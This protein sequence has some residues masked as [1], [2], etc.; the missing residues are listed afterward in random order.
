MFGTQGVCTDKE[1]LEIS[2]NLECPICLENKR[3]ISQP[4]CNHKICI[5]CFRQCYYGDDNDEYEPEAPLY[6]R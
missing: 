6:R 3:I 1:I 5:N 2:D 4:N